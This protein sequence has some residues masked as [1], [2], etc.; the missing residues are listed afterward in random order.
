MTAYKELLEGNP[1]ETEIRSYLMDGERVSVTLR[2]PEMLRDAAKDEAALRGMSFS[3]FV[4]TYMIEE[5]AKR[6]A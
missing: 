1:S 6:G 4:R 3:A 2:I 5:L